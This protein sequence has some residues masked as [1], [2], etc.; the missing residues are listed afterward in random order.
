MENL[1][2][3]ILAENKHNRPLSV[4][5]NDVNLL[6][7]NWS[8]FGLNLIMNNSD[9]SKSRIFMRN[10]NKMKTGKVQISNST[11]GYLEVTNEFDINLSDS[12]INGS[13][14]LSLTLINATGN[15]VNITVM[16][17][18]RFKSW[19]LFLLALASCVNGLTFR[20]QNSCGGRLTSNTE[21][22]I[23]GQNCIHSRHAA[24]SY[25]VRI[26]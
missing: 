11:F 21:V 20:C 15:T 8:I 3:M 10:T 25:S 16:N 5:F 18:R 19:L 1:T 26:G 2:A 23:F 13:E 14:R 17:T 4:L 12:Y 22:A 9:L 6:S 7:S 24:S